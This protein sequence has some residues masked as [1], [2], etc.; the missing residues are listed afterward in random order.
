MYYGLQSFQTSCS[1]SG[2][3]PRPPYSPAWPP[4]YLAAQY[5]HAVLALVS[6]QGPCV[7]SSAE[8]CSRSAPSLPALSSPPR[9]SMTAMH[10]E[11]WSWDRR[12]GTV[13]RWWGREKSSNAGGRGGEQER[14][15]P[16]G[17]SQGWCIA[18]DD[19]FQPL[20]WQMLNQSQ[21][22]MSV[23]ERCLWLKAARCRLNCALEVPGLPKE[24]LSLLSWI[25]LSVSRSD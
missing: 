10:R 11:Q 13:R 20:D 22:L 2:S 6:C 19:K 8:P 16:L 17:T 23:K 1:Q 15:M 12:M 21:V 4:V 25:R 5:H 7:V 3:F 24:P 14:P 9:S 18:R